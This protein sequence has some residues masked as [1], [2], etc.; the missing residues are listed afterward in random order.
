MLRTE[1]GSRIEPFMKA[2]GDEELIARMARNGDEAAFAALYKR[3]EKAA[4]NIA[5]HITGTREGAEEAVQEGMFSLW[6]SAKTFK[7]GPT[8]ARNWLLK[9]IANKSLHLSRN[10]RKRRQIEQPMNLDDPSVSFQ[11]PKD[12]SAKQ[13]E[14][15]ERVSVVGK[16][17]ALLAIEDRRLVAL[18]Y[19]AGLSQ[20][21][22]A[23]SLKI[24]QRTVSYRIKGAMEKLRALLTK[25][26]VTAVVLDSEW[27]E[28]ICSSQAVP[29]ALGQSVLAKV[30]GAAMAGGPG[31][32]AVRIG[33][34]TKAA[35]ALLATLFAGGLLWSMA[36]GDPLNSVSPKSTTAQSSTLKS[37][38]I[39]SDEFDGKKLNSF[40]EIVKPVP[41]GIDLVW[42]QEDS[43]LFLF[44]GSKAARIKNEQLGALLVDG[45]KV[46]AY[47]RVELTSQRVTLD[48]RP[49]E[50]YLCLGEVTP[51]GKKRYETAF[52]LLD[53]N[54]RVLYRGGQKRE[55]ENTPAIEKGF[56]ITPYKTWRVPGDQSI[57]AVK[58]ER[59]VIDRSGQ[60]WRSVQNMKG[61]LS[62]PVSGGIKSIRVRLVLMCE[63]DLCASW[64]FE[65]LSLR[66]LAGFSFQA[67]PSAPFEMGVPKALKR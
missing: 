54:D 55:M 15:T 17:M 30:S 26:G 58:F 34:Q 59:I 64:S 29:V 32:A 21:S 67:A 41:K 6:R 5:W 40:W 37:E 13:V 53:E 57:S 44:A 16:A 28:L 45:K 3:H 9:I 62:E 18:Y 35:A 10:T 22:I 19:G 7:P 38:V 66:R 36:K 31:V 1:L 52:E 8:S 4:Y 51:G 14:D 33:I 50:V 42:K 27:P 20:D 2:I 63:K 49:L 56:V 39:Y 60:I 65:R 11:D 48:Q 24:P 25:H 46:N 47:P 61:F 23:A 12:S 43:K